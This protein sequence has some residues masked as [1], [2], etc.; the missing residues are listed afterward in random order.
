[1]PKLELALAVQHL[2]EDARRVS[3]DELTFQVARLFGWNRRGSDIAA[4]L[5]RAV[6][7]LL[8]DGVLQSDGQYVKVP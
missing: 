2:V 4:A 8:R 6:D 3:R 7:K 1:V 5:D